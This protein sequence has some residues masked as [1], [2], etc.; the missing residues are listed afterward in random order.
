[1]AATASPHVGGGGVGLIQ[2]L[3]VGRFELLFLAS[4]IFHP[5]FCG[6]LGELLPQSL[7]EF[8][9][10]LVL[11][12]FPER[13]GAKI[14]FGFHFENLVLY[15]N[16]AERSPWSN[17]P[18]RKRRILGPMQLC[19]NGRRLTT[20]WK[21]LC[22]LSGTAQGAVACLYKYMGLCLSPA[23]SRWIRP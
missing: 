2:G 14:L 7:V 3:P 21:Q 22:N 6:T 5:G 16:T 8:L 11:L 18:L 17:F 20:F 1:M 10:Y 19:M 13:E 23:E 4:S 12:I 9:G 15:R